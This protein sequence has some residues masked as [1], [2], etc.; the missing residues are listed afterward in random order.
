MFT[1]MS[2][3]ELGMPFC[4]KLFLI[5]TKLLYTRGFNKKRHPIAWQDG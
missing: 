2:K 1:S 4:Y 3:H 5:K